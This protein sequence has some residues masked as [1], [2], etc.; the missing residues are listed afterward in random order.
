MQ[1]ADW[2]VLLTQVEEVGW[3]EEAV[4]C[5]MGKAKSKK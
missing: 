5:K 3:A 2:R 4:V 1:E